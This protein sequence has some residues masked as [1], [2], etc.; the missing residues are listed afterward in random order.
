MA[1]AIERELLDSIGRVTREAGCRLTGVQ[2]YL[3][4]AFN[5]LALPLG[6][7]NFVFV[8]AE[9]GRVTLAAG[10]RGG[11]T[12]VRNCTATVDEGG[13][14]ALI[15]REL[16]LICGDG[17]P[18]VIVHAPRIVANDFACVDELGWKLVPAAGTNDYAMAWG[19]GAP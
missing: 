2:P 11:W 5:P 15:E 19:T 14:Q 17:Q 18:E 16:E 12:S 9:P 10:D 3:M 7:R 6:R 8:L 4:H 1:C 13:L